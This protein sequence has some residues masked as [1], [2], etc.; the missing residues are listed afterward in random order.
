MTWRVRRPEAPR[1][2]VRLRPSRVTRAAPPAL[3]RS[4]ISHNE[5]PR[6]CSLK[7]A[8]RRVQ[9]M[10]WSCHAPRIRRTRQP[11]LNLALAGRALLGTTVVEP[12]D[13]APAWPAR[14][15]AWTWKVYVCPSAPWNVSEVAVVPWVTVRHV[16]LA[17]LVL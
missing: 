7:V 17:T 10:A 5:P 11:A 13:Q 1:R 12:G 3:V 4:P 9:M 15:T 6:K 16:G 2:T 14:L 8:P